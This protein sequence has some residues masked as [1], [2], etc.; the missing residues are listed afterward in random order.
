MEENN[1]E[2]TTEEQAP[3]TP[4]TKTETPKTEQKP[5]DEKFEFDKRLYTEDGKFNQE[6][7]KEYLKEREAEKQK[8]EERLL[9]LR[10]I[11]SRNGETV[12][13]AEEY[14]QDFAPPK[15]FEKFFSENTPKE[16][17]EYLGSMQANLARKYLDMGLNKQQAVDVSNTILEIMEQVGVL[18]TRTE[19]QQALARENYYKEQESRL[20]ANA[21]NIIREAEIFIM[22]SNDFDAQQKNKMID[23]IKEGD[24]GIVS[25]MHSLKDAFGNG[26]GGVPTNITNL[27]GLKPDNELWQEYKTASPERRNEIIAQRHKAGR[28]GKLAD[29]MNI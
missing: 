7:A 28:P 10:R 12:E 9:G 25:I 29:V 11:V 24:M 20:G 2:V 21:K 1:E 27:G 16:T 13:K 14:F 4:A 6:G 26:T 3:E 23:M 18:D 8:Y 17:K 5:N 22:N 15:K 19:E